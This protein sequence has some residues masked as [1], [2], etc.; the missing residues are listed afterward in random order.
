VLMDA[1]AVCSF[2]DYFIICAGDT[3][4]QIRAI[5]DEIEQSLKKEGVLPHHHEGTIDSGWLLIDYGD[6]IVHIFGAS[7]REFYQLDKLWEEAK[8]LLRIQ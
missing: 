1:R 7:E 2:A 5:Y 6:V 3:E 8:T 4:R